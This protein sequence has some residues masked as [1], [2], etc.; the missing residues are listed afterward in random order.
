[1]KKSAAK[2]QP[3]KFSEMEQTN[4]KNYELEDVRNLEKLLDM[5]SNNPYGTLDKSLFREKVEVMTLD[6]MGM[7][8]GRV[9]VAL[10]NRQSVL[11]TRL[12]DAFEDFQRRHRS[13]L[14]GIKVDPMNK[15][16][17]A[18]AEISDLIGFPNKPR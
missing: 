12:I 17:D 11:R 4:G 10:S 7:L 6:Q 18:Y 3:K 9:G 13:L 14:G 16:S 15:N 1:M 5:G 2:K 8:A